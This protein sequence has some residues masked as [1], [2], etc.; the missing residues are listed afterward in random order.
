ME[1]YS[2]RMEIHRYNVEEQR[3]IK[4]DNIWIV[5]YPYNQATAPYSMA[6]VNN[7]VAPEFAEDTIAYL[8]YDFG[9]LYLIFEEAKHDDFV[10]F[11]DVVLS[12]I[13][14]NGNVT[15][16]GKERFVAD[17]YRLERNRDSRKVIQLPGYLLTPRG[18]MRAEIYPV[19]SFGKTG[20]PL[21]ID[22]ENP[23]SKPRQEG[24][25]RPQE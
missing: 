23:A 25:L 1:I 18:N 11:Y 19:E 22:F 12:D 17:F 16:K 15:V 5:P 3:E 2:D 7:R 4:P 21:V 6:R 14:E 8:R 10:H 13:D 24:T 20:K 9:F